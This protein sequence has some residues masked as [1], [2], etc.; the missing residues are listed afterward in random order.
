MRRSKRLSL[1]RRF[2]LA[3]CSLGPRS[4]EGYFASE[5]LDQMYK[6]TPGVK[7]DF[8]GVALHPYT[9]HYQELTREIEGLRNVLKANHDP[10]RDFGS[11]SL[12]GA[13]NIHRGETASRLASMA[14]PPS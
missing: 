11:P 2:Y 5:F 14:R 8:S 3:G 4:T 6:R 7:A 12:A 9:Y 1:G 13:P 10:T